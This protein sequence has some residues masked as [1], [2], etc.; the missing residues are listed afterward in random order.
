MKKIRKLIREILE[1]AMVAKDA[2]P[3]LHID[4]EWRVPQVGYKRFEYDLVGGGIVFEQPHNPDKLYDFI[5]NQGG[6]LIIGIGHYKMAKKSDIIKAA[7]SLKINKEGKI[8]Y[9]DNTSGHYRPEKGNLKTVFNV[10]Y[11]MGVL[12]PDVKVN[13]K[14]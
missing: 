8:Y 11:N 13:Y 1:V 4:P 3:D 9:I 5:I 6:E 10:L 14:Y 2:F 12:S 7:G